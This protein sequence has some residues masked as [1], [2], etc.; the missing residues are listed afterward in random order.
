MM[1][2]AAVV[3]AFHHVIVGSVLNGFVG[4]LAI[5]GWPALK[6]LVRS[7]QMQLR[8]WYHV[9]VNSR[10]FEHWVRPDGSVEVCVMRPYLRNGWYWKSDRG[11]RR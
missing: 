2:T 3:G 5:G 1:I 4:V 6:R 10:R 8:H 7:P 9:M 11:G